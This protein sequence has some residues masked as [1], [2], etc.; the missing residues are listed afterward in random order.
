MA[1]P[2]YEND[3]QL[4]QQQPQQNLEEVDQVDGPIAHPSV[5][6]SYVN[7]ADYLP[8]HDNPQSVTEE[9]LMAWKILAIAM[10][11]ALKDHYQQHL[12]T[13]TTTPATTS[14]N[15]SPTENSS[16]A[17]IQILPNGQIKPQWN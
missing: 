3:E 9:D 12:L 11:K 10:C 16:T 6:Q 13:T 2:F 5:Y 4:Q 17:V 14:S 1:I 15:S 8:H 7:E